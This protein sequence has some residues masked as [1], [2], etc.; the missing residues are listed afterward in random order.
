MT[1]LA[2]CFSLLATT[3]AL[4]VEAPTITISKS[5]SIAV[6]I[7]PVQGSDASTVSQ[8]LQNDLSL[9][10]LFNVASGQ[11]AAFTITGVSSGNTLQGK[12]TD[13]NGSVVVARAY[14][15]S[16]RGKV[17]EFVDDIVQT[18]TGQKGIAHSKIA[19][20][21][22]R[23]G[24]KEIYLADYD[25]ANAQQL[26]RDNSISV[27]PR[28][29][30]DGR[31]LLYTGYKSGYAD[32]YRIDFSNGA[33]ERIIKFPG[34][35]SGAVFSPDSSRIAVTLSKDGNPELYVTGASGDSPRR[36][37]RTPG[38]ESSPSWAPNGSELV[39]SCDDQG[40][41]QLFRTSTGFGGAHRI[42]AGYSY[43]TEPDWSPDGK[44]IV[45]NVREGGAFQVATVSVSGGSAR[46]LC[47]GERPAWGPDSRHVICA[48][49]GAL[50]IIDSV[51]GKK[52]KV[53]DGLGQIT[54]PT[55]S[56]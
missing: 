13:H 5:D 51:T 4:A 9:S 45:F 35:N 14:S 11:N 40:G 26:T 23:S 27:S 52:A 37:T 18:L 46:V 34:T 47:A 56:R 32:V 1:K 33:R 16:S 48:Q 50:Y 12:V 22:N 3:A 54:E 20:V 6:S 30:A 8:V 15:G 43:C 49:G 39:Y 25:G 29:S 19:F 10:G 2:L 44:S 41:P 36:L 7:A 31:Q 17:H 42:S 55:W 24:H 28:L 38:V 53:L 21:S